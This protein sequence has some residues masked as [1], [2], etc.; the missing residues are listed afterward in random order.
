VRGPVD[1]WAFRRL[2]RKSAEI[3][4]GGMDRSRVFLNAHGEN[5]SEKLIPDATLLRG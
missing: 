4:V 3:V 2:L 5:I 1:F